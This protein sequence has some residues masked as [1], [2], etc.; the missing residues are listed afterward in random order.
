MGFFLTSLQI[1]DMFITDLPAS[2]FYLLIFLT[3]E[4]Q[5]MPISVCKNSATLVNLKTFS[6]SL[7]WGKNT[8][9]SYY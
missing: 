6:L 1:A 5:E 2:F 3:Y 9:V 8:L 7:H 4:M